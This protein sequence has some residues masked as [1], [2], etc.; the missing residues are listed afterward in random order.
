MTS[1]VPA[2]FAFST[3]PITRRTILMWSTPNEVPQVATAVVTPA[4]WQAMT[5]V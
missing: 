2:V 4:R 1:P 5:S 3:S